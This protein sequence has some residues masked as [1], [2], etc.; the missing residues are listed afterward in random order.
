[1]PG[2]EINLSRPFRVFCSALSKLALDGGAR[3]LAIRQWLFGDLMNLSILG[4]EVKDGR[5]SGKVHIEDGNRQPPIHQSSCAL[6]INPPTSY[7]WQYMDWGL[8]V[9]D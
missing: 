3:V 5:N 1:M 2:S 9:P 7:S 4:V 6:I 8:K